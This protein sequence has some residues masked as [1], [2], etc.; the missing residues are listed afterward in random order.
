MLKQVVY[1]IRTVRYWFKQ[2]AVAVFYVIINRFFIP[3]KGHFLIT[4]KPINVERSVV[5]HEVDNTSFD[6]HI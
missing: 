1:V 3:C 5:L 6:V 2:A 4:S